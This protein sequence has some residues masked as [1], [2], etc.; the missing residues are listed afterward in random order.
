CIKLN[1]TDFQQTISGEVH[2][3]ISDAVVAALSAEPET[4][5]ELE[6]ALARFAKPLDGW[7]LFAPLR[8]GA[9]FEPYD[10]GIMIVDLAARVVMID[11]TCSTPPKPIIGQFF[12]NDDTEQA[13]VL[14]FDPGDP[15]QVKE[16]DKEEERSSF[17]DDLPQTY[18]IRY[19]DGENL[20]DVELLYH[21]P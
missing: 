17:L 21:L 7:S 4:I 18:G 19:H 13:K 16:A 15:D 1:L 9:D 11:S 12:A 10:A 5:H 8:A 20:T 2:G 14:G 6:L 3:S